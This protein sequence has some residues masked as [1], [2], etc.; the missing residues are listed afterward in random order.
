MNTTSKFGLYSAVIAV[1][2]PMINLPKPSE[3]TKQMLGFA[4]VTVLKKKNISIFL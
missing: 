4:S 2:L 1:Y 3:Q